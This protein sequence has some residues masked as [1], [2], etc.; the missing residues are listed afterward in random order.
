MSNPSQQQIAFAYGV[1]L[2]E[3]N[4]DT[5]AAMADIQ[6][7]IAGY[8]DPTVDPT[9]AADLVLDTPAMVGNEIFA[10]GLPWFA[11]V[12]RAKDE[13]AQRGGPQPAAVRI[14]EFRKWIESGMP[15]QQIVKP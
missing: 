12:Q 11:V 7:F 14:D 1:Y 4:G 15:P 9:H 10:A 5:A 13:Y 8:S 6:T 2:K 3:H